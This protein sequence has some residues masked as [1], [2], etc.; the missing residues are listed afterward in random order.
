MRMAI[1]DPS[2]CFRSLSG[3]S[4]FH[5]R[6]FLLRGKLIDLQSFQKS[7]I[8]L[9]VPG[10]MERRAVIRFLTLTGL[11]PGKIYSELE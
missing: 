1:R 7:N 3:S 8:C 5:V 2:A 9:Y 11:N 4:F 10:K 6:S